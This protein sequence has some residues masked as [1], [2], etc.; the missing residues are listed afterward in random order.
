MR[1]GRAGARALPFSKATPWLGD[2]LGL[3]IDDA[4]GL[5]EFSP[6]PEL[7]GPEPRPPL[8]LP[9]DLPLKPFIDVGL[10]EEYLPFQFDPG[11]PLLDQ[12]LKG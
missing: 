12:F 4:R 6:R 8:L 2:E 3:T 10:P 9:L 11:E 1:A 5:E 7:Y